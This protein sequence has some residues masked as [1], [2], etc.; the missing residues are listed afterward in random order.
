MV[1]SNSLFSQIEKLKGQDNYEVWSIRIESALKKEGLWKSITSLVAIDSPTNISAISSIKLSIEDGPLLNIRYIKSAKEAWELF[2]SRYAPKG[3]SSVFLIC[4]EF[5]ETTSEGFNSIEDYL[6]KVK[7]LTDQLEIKDLKL[8]NQVIMAWVLNHL[9]SDYE[10]LVS[11]LTQSLRNNPEAFNLETLFAN[12]IDEGKRL[13]S[14]ERTQALY[15]H[16][17]AINA[18]NTKKSFKSVK[19]KHCSNCKMTLYKV[20]DCYFLFPNK[21]PAA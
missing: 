1:S 20:K 6:N 7:Q 21:A 15:T 5:F 13:N 19:G 2:N 12:L 10:G 4:K 11:N 16:T 3:F 8:P 9:S 18:K 14:K 17:K